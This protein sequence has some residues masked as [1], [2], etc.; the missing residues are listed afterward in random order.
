MMY[1]WKEII[2]CNVALYTLG[3][4]QVVENVV[5]NVASVLFKSTN[6]P[7]SRHCHLKGKNIIITGANRGIGK[8]IA[9]ELAQCGCHVILACRNTRE[10]ENMLA[11]ETD[12]E[13]S[14]LMRVEH[15]DL[16]SFESVLACARR[17]HDIGVILDGIICNAGIMAPPSYG[18]SED[19]YE[20]QMQVNCISHMLLVH[21][22]LCQGSMHDSID[23][24][25]VFCSSFAYAGASMTTWDDVMQGLTCSRSPYNPKIQY[26]N[27][28]LL[29][30]LAAANLQDT[31]QAEY[32]IMATCC[33]VNPGVVD[34][35][36][37][38]TFCRGEFPS[39][40]RPLT[41]TL[42]DLLFHVTLRRPERA[43]RGII[44]TLTVPSESVAGKYVTIG[45]LGGITATPSSMQV[46][47]LA[48]GIFRQIMILI[49]TGGTQ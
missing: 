40:M 12:P 17:L 38:R 47:H 9:I 19:G 14:R 23:S 18:Q 39:W 30:I 32:G 46:R 27:T 15:I 35:E 8:H 26:A 6:R 16:A 4:S 5:E 49:K 33:S 43:A 29:D 3:L 24:R 22:L 10:A 25:I 42:L 41:D 45:P 44:Q 1:P 21:T 37:A 31:I 20:M 48:N 13:I 34:T 7:E 28:K 2:R 36:L 11:R